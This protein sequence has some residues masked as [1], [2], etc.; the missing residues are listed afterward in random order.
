MPLPTERVPS[1]A[2]SE[3]LAWLTSTLWPARGDPRIGVRPRRVSAH[4]LVL[5]GAETSRGDGGGGDSGSGPP[6]SARLL[7][8]ASGESVERSGEEAGRL[9]KDEGPP[10]A[11][12]GTVLRR[13]DAETKHLGEYDV[14]INSH[15]PCPQRAYS[16][17]CRLLVYPIGLWPPDSWHSSGLGS[18]AAS[19]SG[20]PTPGAARLGSAGRETPGPPPGS[21]LACGGG[22]GREGAPLRPL[23]P[24]RPARP[25]PC[26][27]CGKKFSLKHQLQ[28]HLRVHTGEKPFACRLCPQR[29]RD[30]SAMTKHLR[31]H[32]VAPYRCP[33]CPAGCPSLSAMQAHL[34]A[35]PPGQ[36]SPGCT[37]RC[38]FL[39]SSSSSS[40]PA[41]HGPPP[42]RS[43]PPQAP[44]GNPRPECLPPPS[45]SEA[46]TQDPGSDCCDGPQA[47][48][49]EASETMGD[50]D[51]DSSAYPASTPTL[52]TAI[53]PE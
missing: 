4:R 51:R 14:T 2:G 11:G 17:A 50:R 5:A 23:R 37:V 25:H 8:L 10:A 27:R 22:P 38:T 9:W 41:S 26:P 53:G 44:T 34:R 32:G 39:Y 12:G 43:P 19:A 30:F 7:V 6:T 31:T 28:T 33:L 42:P 18:S 13:R 48:E 29:S 16:L 52:S 36:L 35:H 3:R 1:P 24:P 40:S 49:R 21:A 20:P 15:I 46:P 47:P 45:P